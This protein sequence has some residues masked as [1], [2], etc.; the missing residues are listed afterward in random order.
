MPWIERG[1]VT[2]PAGTFEKFEVYDL[3]HGEASK[4]EISGPVNKRVVRLGVQ[5]GRDGLPGV[6]AVPA[7]QAV[8][9]YAA[10]EGTE[11]RKALTSFL[12]TGTEMQSLARVNRLDSVGAA[13]LAVTSADVRDKYD[14]AAEVLEPWSNLSSPGVTALNVSAQSNRLVGSGNAPQAAKI[15]VTPS[16]SGLLFTARIKVPNTGGNVFAGLAGSATQVPQEA[17]VDAY[18]VGTDGNRKPKYLRGPNV[19]NVGSNGGQAVIDESVTWAGG[20]ECIV[21]AAVLPDGQVSTVITH[22]PSGMSYMRFGNSGPITTSMFPGGGIGSMLLYAGAPGSGGSIG[23]VAAIKTV[24]S[25]K[26]KTVG[27]ENVSA[28]PMYIQS[29]VMDGS[30]VVDRRVLI[31]APGNDP[32]KPSPLAV[33]LHN[34]GGSETN[35]IQDARIVPFVQALL[36]NGFNVVMMNMRGANWGNDAG[37]SDA[38]A[39]Y[40]WATSIVA[41]SKVVLTGQSMGGQVGWQLLVRNQIPNVAAALFVAP[42]TSLQDLYGTSQ[43]RTQIHA[44]FNVSTFTDVPAEY[45]TERRAG[46]EFRMIPVGIVTSPDDA[47]CHIQYARD[48]IGK[49]KT[50]APSSVLFEST[51]DHMAATQFQDAI[52][53][54]LPWLK[55]Q[56]A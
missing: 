10:T 11:L 42:V 40:E 51:G 8:A 45:K 52:S 21:T 24:A 55:A 19:G 31:I 15:A 35:S 33:Y 6:N 46:H 26:T 22:V 54:G 30:T 18:M 29:F 56:I 9:T 39:A 4:I 48:L 25:R 53:V 12:M 27:G 50:Y 28:H 16:T 2:G 37:R 17:S 23:P 20:D 44:A 43:Y 5:A 41:T 32:Q 13:R 14:A 38:T 49:V 3:P 7:D 1:E 36:A 47:V 34:A